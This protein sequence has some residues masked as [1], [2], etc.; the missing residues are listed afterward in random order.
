MSNEKQTALRVNILQS[1]ID[2]LTSLSFSKKVNARSTLED[3]RERL[4][5][6]PHFDPFYFPKPD[7]LVILAI[8]K[9]NFGLIGDI[10]PKEA[11]K[12]AFEYLCN[13]LGMLVDG[14]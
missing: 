6:Y 1:C 11:S 12:Q 3:V 8:S 9:I 13:S 2:E 5:G 10:P 14:K 7:R 4:N